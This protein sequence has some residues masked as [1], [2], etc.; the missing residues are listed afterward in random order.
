MLQLHPI[1]YRKPLTMDFNVECCICK[2]WYSIISNALISSHMY[3]IHMC[4]IY[5][6]SRHWRCYFGWLHWSKKCN[7]NERERDRKGKR[8]VVF[9]WIYYWLFV[10]IIIN[11]LLLCILPSS[12]ISSCSKI[13]ISKLN[14]ISFDWIEILFE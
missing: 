13:W 12:S 4:Y 14:I 7:E 1:Q 8:K 3:P 5:C 6:V 2:R 11:L 9:V 10:I